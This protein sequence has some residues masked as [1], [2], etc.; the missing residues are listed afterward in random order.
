M[1]P[2]T[3]ISV[4][5]FS[6]L[7]SCGFVFGPG[8]SAHDKAYF[9]SVPHIVDTAEET[10]L[11]WSYGSLG[12][13]FTPRYKVMDGALHFSLQGTASTGRMLG[14]ESRLPISEKDARE[15]LRQGGAYWWNT[16]GSKTKLKVNP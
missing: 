13:Y 7:G 1:K 9:E 6:F 10:S 14:Q 15:A 4:C 5:L 11:V 12:F 16:D 3:L 8:Y 2:I